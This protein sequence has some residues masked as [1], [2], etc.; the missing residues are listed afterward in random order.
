MY[1]CIPYPQ[2]TDTVYGRILNCII[3]FVMIIQIHISIDTINF[4]VYSHHRHVFVS[5]S[6]VFSHFYIH[7]LSFGQPAL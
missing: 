3:T 6:L 1:T 7:G 5:S 4:Q 2:L